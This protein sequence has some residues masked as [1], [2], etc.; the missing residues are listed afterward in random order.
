VE[1]RGAW[2]VRRYRLGEE[3]G[4]DLSGSTTAEER[5]AM[6]PGLAAEAYAVERFLVVGAH[7]M[8]VH[9]VPRATGDR[10]VWIAV[11]PEYADRVTQTC[12]LRSAVWPSLKPGKA[13]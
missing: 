5:L 4:G 2:P 3:P 8:A 11:D 1:A 7:A 13:G 6:M 12:S 9:G 10:D